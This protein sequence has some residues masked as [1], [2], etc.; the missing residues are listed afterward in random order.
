[1]L[2]VERRDGAI[3]RFLRPRRHDL[4]GVEPQVTATVK[5]FAPGDNFRHLFH[6][7]Y[8]V[9]VL[10]RAVVNGQATLIAQ[11]L[12]C[13]VEVLGGCARRHQHASDAA[14]SRDVTFKGEDA[15]AVLFDGEVALGQFVDYEVHRGF[16]QHPVGLAG[17]RVAVELRPLAWRIGRVFGDASE[18]EGLGVGPTHMARP[19]F[20]VYGYVADDVVEQL[21]RLALSRLTDGRE[22]PPVETRSAQ[23]F[24][25]RVTRAELQNFLPVVLQ[26]VR[27]ELR[28]EID[29]AHEHRAPIDMI[30]RIDEAG[31]Q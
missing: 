14:R 13:C 24:R 6:I 21:T 30:V 19:G 31:K 1:V 17:H 22:N 29:P 7:L 23:L 8:V 16:L 11:L 25:V 20:N 10:G 12:Q 18:L 4:D 27:R 15:R 28:T 5:S 26:G 9:H 3:E 2:F